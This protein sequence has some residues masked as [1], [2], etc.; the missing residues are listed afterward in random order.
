MP[1]HQGALVALDEQNRQMYGRHMPHCGTHC[2]H[3]C[4]VQAMLGHEGEDHWS[5]ASIE[6]MTQELGLRPDFALPNDHSRRVDGQ[7]WCV[8]VVQCGSRRLAPNRNPW[9]NSCCYSSDQHIYW[10]WRQCYGTEEGHGHDK[11]NRYRVVDV[12]YWC[13]GTQASS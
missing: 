10:S 7:D 8:E 12:L 2:S 6:A 9:C 5:N 13:D 4:N 11:P 3:C 1:L